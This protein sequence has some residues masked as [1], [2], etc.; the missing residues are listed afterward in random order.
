MR[1]TTRLAAV[2]AFVGLTVALGACT[3][4]AAPG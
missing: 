1:R 4:P 3:D 2:S